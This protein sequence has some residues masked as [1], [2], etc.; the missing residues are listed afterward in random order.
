MSHFKTLVIL[1]ADE[2]RT[3]KALQTRLERWDENREVAP[4]VDSDGETS[5][6]NPDARFDWWE[7]GG[8]WSGSMTADE[9]DTFPLVDMAPGWEAY[10]I[11][12][13]RGEWFACGRMGWFGCGFDENPQ[14]DALKYEIASAYPDCVGVLLDMHI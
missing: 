11:V 10:A 6:Y 14:W 7:I 3:T 4:Y 9:R 12:T 2:P 1:K 8:R 5:T 13:P